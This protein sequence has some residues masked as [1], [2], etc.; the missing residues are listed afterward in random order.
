MYFHKT[1]SSD[2]EQFLK[3]TQ[4]LCSGK[5]K[6]LL[7]KCYF[8]LGGLL[9]SLPCSEYLLLRTNERLVSLQQSW[10]MS[11]PTTVS[12]CS[13]LIQKSQLWKIY[14][15]KCTFINYLTLFFCI[16]IVSP[17]ITCNKLN[18]DIQESK[19]LFFLFFFRMY[20]YKNRLR[21]NV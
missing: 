20:I 21:R 10:R 11:F 17:L 14:P 12:H 4:N 19:L 5:G 15:V 16:N 7:G 13:V 6:C 8:Q 1:D 2:F 9:V 18:S 3:S